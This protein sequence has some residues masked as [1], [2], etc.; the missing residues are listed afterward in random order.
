MSGRSRLQAGPRSIAARRRARRSFVRETI[1]LLKRFELNQPATAL[2][3]CGI[4][5]CADEPVG[6]C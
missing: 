4:F 6:A 1:P 3:L 5:S 2:G